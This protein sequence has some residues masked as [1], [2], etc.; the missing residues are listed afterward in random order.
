M[1]ILDTWCQSDCTLGRL[2]YGNFQCFTLELPWHGNSPNISCIPAGVYN[3]CKYQSPK[4]GQVLLFQNVPSRSFIE[5]H[6]GNYTTQI[7][8]CILV[9][10]S[11]QFLNGDEIPDV[12]NS[13]VTLSKLLALVPNQT[14]IKIS[15]V[16]GIF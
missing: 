11:V 3:V 8:G 6:A 13:K 7:E 16:R 1:I 10:D 9:G 2:K 4:H 15:R 14:T 12:A 5:A